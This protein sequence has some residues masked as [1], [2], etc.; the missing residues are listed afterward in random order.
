MT[1][2]ATFNPSYGSGQTVAPGAASARVSVGPGQKTLCITSLNAVQCYVRVGDST[3][4]ASADA[5]RSRSGLKS[6]GSRP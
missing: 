2:L 3:V 6:A 1:V 5:R 4:V